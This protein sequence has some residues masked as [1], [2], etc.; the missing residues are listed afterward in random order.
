[1]TLN[2]SLA[3]KQEFIEPK[4]DVL[5]KPTEEEEENLKQ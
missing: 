2:K 1:L 3:N 4:I 5:S